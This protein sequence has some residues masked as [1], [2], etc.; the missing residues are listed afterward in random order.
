MQVT[1]NLVL[2]TPS[3]TLTALASVANSGLTAM[4]GVPAAATTRGASVGSLTPT[5]PLT[6]TLG[7]NDQFNITVD[8]VGPTLITIPPG[9][10][11]TPAALASAMQTAIGAGFTVSDAP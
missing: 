3:V 8:G 2:G 10:Y 6:L 1:S 5:T 4:F 7:V 11:N 9:T